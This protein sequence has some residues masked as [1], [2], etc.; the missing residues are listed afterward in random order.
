MHTTH[1]PLTDL[2][3]FRLRVELVGSEPPI[4]RE[5]DVRSDLRLSVL[6]QAIQAAFLWWDYHLYRFAV[7]GGFF[8]ESGA[9]ELFVCPFDSAEAEPTEPGMPSQEVRLDQVVQQPGE[10][11]YYLCDY[12]DYWDLTV[13]LTQVRDRSDH[14]GSVEYVDGRRAAPPEDCGGRRTAEQL[15]EVVEDLEY[16]GSDEIAF[17]LHPLDWSAR[18]ATDPGFVAG[19]FNRYPL[20]R[21]LYDRLGRSAFGLYLGIKL[22]I[23]ERSREDL[24]AGQKAKA[25]SGIRRLL[26]L[27]ARPGEQ[28]VKLTGAGYLP[29]ALVA[30]AIEEL[31]STND[32]ITKGRSESTMLQVGEIRAALMKAGVVRKY[33]G[34]LSLTANGRKALQD[35]E[36]LWRQIAQR[37]PRQEAVS[38]DRSYDDEVT[39]LILLTIATTKSP[40]RE[41][42]ALAELLSAAGWQKQAGYMV[43]G[44]DPQ[45]VRSDDPMVA[46]LMYTGRLEERGWSPEVYSAA[47]SALARDAVLAS[48]VPA[49]Q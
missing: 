15:A 43:T 48:A 47:A 17:R 33:R 11:L 38:G 31:P 27:I 26:E 36:E 6:H 16:V 30:E 49:Q 35:P 22:E 4:W 23:L 3:T 28:G 9:T 29:P 1:E 18:A 37:F 21:Q 32:L 2:R 34:R 44:V 42:E 45:D 19:L 8:D 13:T 46:L 10:V 24:T 41:A 12:G 5:L 39:A 25:L 40:S 20:F 7:G 14:A